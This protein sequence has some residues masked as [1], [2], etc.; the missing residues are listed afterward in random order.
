MIWREVILITTDPRPCAGNAC[1]SGGIHIPYEV[2]ADPR[3]GAF[4]LVGSPYTYYRDDKWAL[5]RL[6]A[7][8]FACLPRN[9]GF[10]LDDMESMCIRLITVRRRTPKIYFVISDGCGRIITSSWGDRP[11][12]ICLGDGVFGRDKNPTPVLDHSNIPFRFLRGERGHP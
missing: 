7:E 5:G 1:R 6:S 11:C 3:L 8:Y 12:L 2:F 10:S 4:P 9:S